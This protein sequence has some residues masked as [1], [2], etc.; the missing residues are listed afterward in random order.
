[1]RR[2]ARLH[3]KRRTLSAFGSAYESRAQGCLTE[4]CGKF[5]SYPGGL[6]RGWRVKKDHNVSELQFFVDNLLGRFPDLNV[7]EVTEEL[8]MALAEL[9]VDGRY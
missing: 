9:L 7:N 8:R 4:R 6:T 3:G 2:P 5:A 1:M